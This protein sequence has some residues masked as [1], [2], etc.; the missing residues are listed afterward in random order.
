MKYWVPSLEVGSLGALRLIVARML[1]VVAL[2]HV[3]FL[4]AVAA[5]RNLDVIATAL[6]ASLLAAV[7]LLLYWLGRS[8]L[9]M[10]FALAIALVGQTSMLVFLMKGHPWQTEMHFYY[11]A[12][13]AMLAG[14]CGWRV[15][16]LAAGLIA[17]EHAVFNMVMPDA[18]Y[19]GGSD[20]PRVLVHAWVVVV[21]SA[22]LLV[23]GAAIRAA[24]AT[25]DR[26]REKA[27]E[28]A[29]DRERLAVA[30]ESVLGETTVRANGTRELLERFEAEMTQSIDAL[31]GR[32]EALL[33]NADRLG[34]VSS[35]TAAQ[36]IK[37]SA[38]S[39]D[40][41]RKVE[42]TAQAGHELSQ[43]IH[44]V[45]VSAAKSTELAAQAVGEAS[46]ASDTMGEMAN[47][48][49]EIGKVTGLISGIAAQTNLLAL[50]A[51]IEAARAG[52]A[53][54]GF[55]VVAQE[56]KALAS[57]TAKATEEIARRVA[58]MQDT[59]NRSVAAIEA[60]SVKIRELENVATSIAVAVD[61]QAA[62]THEI[63]ANVTSAA[64]GVGHVEESISAIED[65][66]STNAMAVGEVAE[67]AQVVADQTTTMRA[68]VR[69]FT[70]DIA[71][72]RA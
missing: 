12:V 22:V 41:A 20:L 21:E 57:Q 1:I 50:N 51:T 67:T 36:M 5:W 30:R 32:A 25:A 54:R 45:G 2:I 8:T 17:V 7:P 46:R 27:E 26:M 35:K 16:C 9:M 19:G 66:A 23:I 42:L 11:F 53:G 48:S 52:E 71:R 37:V 70:S 38:V 34:A 18:I 44:Q 63:A 3:P 4:I 6:G 43:T 64:S 55:S 40:T 61:Q 56:V 59:S 39:E 33:G 24:F 68:R 62:A 72:L 14:F 65:L 10:S 47:V 13:L 15:I 60:V 58:A 29:A 31:H 28:L 69:A 49:A